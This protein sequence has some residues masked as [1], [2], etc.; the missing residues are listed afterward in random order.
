MGESQGLESLFWVT[1]KECNINMN[2]N[3]YIIFNFYLKL[4]DSSLCG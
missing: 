2:I 1:Y 3:L 4:Y